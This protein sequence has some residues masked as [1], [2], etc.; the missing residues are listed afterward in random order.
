MDKLHGSGAVLGDAGDEAESISRGDME[1]A[2]PV[3]EDDF[4]VGQKPPE[5]RVDLGVGVFG[6]CE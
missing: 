5:K 2:R 1:F 3:A 4:V 6:Q